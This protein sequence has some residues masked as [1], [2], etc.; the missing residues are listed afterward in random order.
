MKCALESNVRD[1]GAVRGHWALGMRQEEQNRWVF[2]EEMFQPRPQGEKGQPGMWV[3]G[4]AFG[5]QGMVRTD[6]LS[7]T[8]HGTFVQG[9]RERG[10][11]NRAPAVR[12]AGWLRALAS[13]GL[14][15]SV[16]GSIGGLKPGVAQFDLS[17][18]KLTLVATPPP[19]PTCMSRFRV[20]VK[21][22]GYPEEQV[23]VPA[24]RGV[25]SFSRC[26]HPIP[27]NSPLLPHT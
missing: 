5:T 16:T 7:R 27:T 11:R 20:N 4:K 14:L 19:F 3:P 2:Q 17:F 13:L 26:L 9:E 6:V 18:R 22:W 23:M 21:I 12:T 24:P 10:G 15:L 25:L 8:Q 1:C